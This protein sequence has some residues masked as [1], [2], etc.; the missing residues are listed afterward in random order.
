MQLSCDVFLVPATTSYNIATVFSDLGRAP[1]P[2]QHE[3][4]VIWYIIHKAK[5]SKFISGQFA[6]THASSYIS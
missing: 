4:G 5:Q 3:T 2:P 1:T 6:S